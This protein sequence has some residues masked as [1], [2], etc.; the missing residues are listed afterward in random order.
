MCVVIM[1]VV[2]TILA[3]VIDCPLINY[4]ILIK[5]IGQSQL[6]FLYYKTNRD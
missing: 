4:N 1:D 5:L 2:E 6:A 3:E